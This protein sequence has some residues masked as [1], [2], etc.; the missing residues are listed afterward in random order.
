MKSLSVVIPTYNE[1]KRLPKTIAEVE[2]YLLDNCP[3]SEVIISE[4]GSTD[5]TVNYI[6]NLKLRVPLRLVI[7]PEREGKGMGVKRGI[8]E[9]KKD[10]VLFMDADNSTRLSEI[11]K[12]VSLQDEFDV[13]IGSR[14]AGIVQKVKQNL[15]RR[16]VSRL[17]AFSVRVIT[18]LGYKDTQCGF[19]MF[20]KEAAKKIFSN[21]S[22]EGWGFDVEVLLLAKKFSFKVAEV[23]VS[24]SDAEGSH[25]RSGQDSWRTFLEV[26]KIKRNVKKV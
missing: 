23:G 10:W 16:T 15:V 19:K 9:S 8:L 22:T 17:G 24:W 20:S 25:L 18:G 3:D 12:F 26:L 2:K 21:L 1:R 4:A 6:K 11:E 13:I 14:Y 7:A 5:G